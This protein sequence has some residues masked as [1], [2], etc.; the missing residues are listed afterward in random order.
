MKRA[1]IRASLLIV[2]MAGVYAVAASQAQNGPTPVKVADGVW[3]QQHNDIGK[4]GWLGPNVAWIEFADYVAV[5]DT[6]FP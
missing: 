6:S 4:P 3:F 1:M 2:L 5:I